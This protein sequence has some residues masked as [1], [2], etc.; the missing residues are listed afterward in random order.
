MRGAVRAGGIAGL[1]TCGQKGRRLVRLPSRH[2]WR[3]R[4]WAEM[5]VWMD[6][7]R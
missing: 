2:G 5:R 4:V 3:W 6:G 1:S 7:D